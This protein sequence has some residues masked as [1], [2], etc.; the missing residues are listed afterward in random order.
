M[1]NNGFLLALGAPLAIIGLVDAF[2][3]VAKNPNLTQTSFLLQLYG[4][5]F[6]MLL[7]MIF[8]GLACRAFEDKK[9][10]YEFIFQLNSNSSLHWRE[11]LEVRL[12]PGYDL[13]EPN[14]LANRLY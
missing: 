3:D 9:I 13:F 4:G 2:T 8:F 6:L 10:N 14:N 12:I 1:F 7:L 11:L 5:Y